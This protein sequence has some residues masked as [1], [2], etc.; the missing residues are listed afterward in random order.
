MSAVVGGRVPA[1]GAALPYRANYHIPDRPTIVPVE[2]PSPASPFVQALC[3]P[4]PSKR[5]K[6]IAAALSAGMEA[7]APSLTLAGGTFVTEGTETLRLTDADVALVVGAVK[8]AGV[9]VEAVELP[10]NEIGDAGVAS[11]C[12][13]LTD[14]SVYACAVTRLG[15]LGND[16]SAA[17]A[18]LLASA[19]LGNRTVRSLDLSWNDLG[20]RGAFAIAEALAK[21]TTLEELVLRRASIPS[22]AVIA[23]LAI[24]RTQKNLLRLEMDSPRL[25]GLGDEVAKHAA[26]VLELNGTLRHLRLSACKI[27]DEGAALLAHALLRNESLESLALPANKIGVVGAEALASLLVQKGTLTA[28]DLSSNSV[29][30]DGAVALGQALAQTTALKALNLQSNG[31]GDRGLAAVAAGMA[32]NTTV[33]ELKLWGNHF[34]PDAAAAFHE[35]CHG[36]LETLAVAVDVVTSVVDGVVEVAAGV[37]RGQLSGDALGAPRS[38]L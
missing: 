9:V 14:S 37:G 3:G 25:P 13:L 33:S 8:A 10:N 29:D 2:A 4:S 30:D 34:G 26:R 23:V 35:L 5:Q 15:L 19:L 24:M 6:Q 28:L 32:D 11:L 12:E 18:E 31:I 20:G 7:A 21:N 36:R 38:G 1:N 17:G 22:D 16:F 27:D